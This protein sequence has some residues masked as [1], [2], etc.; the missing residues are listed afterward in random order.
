MQR[1]EGRALSCPRMNL[2]QT[3]LCL[4]SYGKASRDTISKSEFHHRVRQALRAN[5]LYTDPAA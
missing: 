4:Q 2:E 5:L 3:D 1:M